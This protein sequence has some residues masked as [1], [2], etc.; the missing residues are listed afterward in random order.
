M[1]LVFSISIEITQNTVNKKS[2]VLIGSLKTDMQYAILQLRLPLNIIFSVINCSV[3][4][5]TCCIVCIVPIRL[6]S[7]QCRCLI[8]LEIRSVKRGICPIATLQSLAAAYKGGQVQTGRKYLSRGPSCSHFC[9]RIRCH[10]NRNR[11]ARNLNDT[12][13]QPGP[14][15]RGVDK[16]QRAIIFQEG[17]VV[18]NFCLK[19]RCHG[20]RGRQ[21]RNFNDTIGQPGPENRVRCKQ[22][23]IIFYGDRVI[24]L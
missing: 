7:V 3:C 24:P 6:I 18:V 22:R 8:K 19:I 2:S 1:N 16:K 15:N 5:F 20:N 17:R 13:G 10:G 9:P 21:G 11:Q 14:E 12:I 4:V 23:A